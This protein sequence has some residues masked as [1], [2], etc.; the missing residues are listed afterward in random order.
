MSITSL[1]PFGGNISFNAQHSPM[2]AFASFTCGHFGT[3]GGIGAQIGK[4]ADQD[5][6]IGIKEGGRTDAAPLRCLPFFRSAAGGG[7]GAADFMVEQ[8][9]P[10]EQAAAAKVVALDASQIQRQYGWATDRWTTDQ[11]T[12]TVYTPFGEIPD[13]ARADFSRLRDALLPAV[14]AELEVDNTRGTQHADSVFRRRIQPAGLAADRRSRVPLAK[15]FRF[16]IS[17]A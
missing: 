8:A 14:I 5:L 2:G 16:A 4:P 1:P 11:F 3:R 6:Y 13:P 9:G 15:D 10:A 17:S 12:F 7:A